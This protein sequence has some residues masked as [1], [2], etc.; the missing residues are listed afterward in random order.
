MKIIL[1]DNQIPFR[2]GIKKILLEQVDFYLAAVG[3]DG[4]DAV[5]LVEK[6]SPDV[7]ILALLLPVVDSLKVA[8]LLRSR[9]PPCSI[10][11]FADEMD[12]KTILNAI[13]CGVTG[14]LLRDSIFTELP[15][16]VRS[17]CTGKGYV[18]QEICMCL[19]NLVS[20]IVSERQE[21][22]GLHPPDET[23]SGMF[24]ITRTESQIVS[25]IAQGLSNKQI[26]KTLN[27]KEGTVRNYVSV[28]LQKTKL[29]HRTQIALYALNNGFTHNYDL[30]GERNVP[31]IQSSYLT[32]G[33][34]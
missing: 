26:A 23:R 27:L 7:A 4:Y 29:K 15:R 16:A 25:F 22:T 31:A 13:C 30:G 6:H 5:N 33:S 32:V 12:D 19:F 9:R 34:L 11:V 20:R 24:R 21:N 1:V 2:D 17:V 3:S 10:I 8:S 18:A 14:L 28:I